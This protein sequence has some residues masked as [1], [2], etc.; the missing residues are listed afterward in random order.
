MK[1]PIK[2]WLKKLN[3]FARIQRPTTHQKRTPK[4]W[5]K[6]NKKR[7]LV[8]IGA[9]IVAGL[10]VFFVPKIAAQY[11]TYVAI[12]QH[13]TPQERD[14][15]VARL[16][17]IR[18]AP[19]K[20]KNSAGM[21]NNVGILRGSIKDYSGAIRA[22]KIAKARNPED[23][24]FDRNMGIT[25][26]YMGDYDSAEEVFRNAM[27]MVPTQPEY[28]LELGELYTY[29]KHDPV[30]AKLFYLQALEKNTNNIEVLKSYANF[31]QNIDMDFHEASKYWQ[32]LAEKD[33]VNKAD[34]LKNAA[35]AQG[36]VK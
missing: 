12:P 7:L 13:F 18:N 6:D 33:S 10:A 21:Y 29:Y 36:R 2:A 1:N 4:E 9:L 19:E 5:L 25:Y 14:Q 23:P 17:D 24:R 28:W 22:F 32:I 3:I 15:V 34:Y 11:D 31:S 30:K 16:N 20:G 8:A 27:N 26:T 35:D